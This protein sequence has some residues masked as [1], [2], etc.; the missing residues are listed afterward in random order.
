ML[1]SPPTGTFEVN[2]AAT[3]ILGREPEALLN[4][5]LTDLVHPDDVVDLER[6][7]G[8]VLHGDRET[9]EHRLRAV[10]PGGDTVWLRA[11][12]ALVATGQPSL[13]IQLEDITAF[14]TADAQ[15]AARADR[16]TLTGL[17]TRERFCQLV[18]DALEAT[19]ADHGMLAVVLID[20]D[21]FRD[22][23]DGLGEHAGDLVL[24]E[25]ARRVRA[26]VRRIDA[27]A[28]FGSDEFAVLLPGL[29]AAEDAVAVAAILRS[30]L[31]SPFE[32]GGMQVH[33]SGSVGI[34]VAPGDGGEGRS[35]IQKADVALARA[36]SLRSGWAVYRSQE[37]DFALDRLALAAELRA[38]IEREELDVAYQPIVETRSGRVAELEALA[39][40]RHVDR[41]PIPPDQFIALAEQ[42]DLIAP[43][44]RLILG[45]A[46]AA[47]AGWRRAG[48]D[49]SVAVNLST[50][51][52]GS[53]DFE[54]VVVE[55]LS[56]AG[57]SPEHLTLEITESALAEDVQKLEQALTSLRELGVCL[58]IDDFGTGYSAMSYLKHLPLEV[59]KIDRSFVQAIAA[60]A[61]DVSIVRSLVRLAHS[62]DL[63][64]V[65]EG[66]ESVDAIELL[67]D[68][69][70]D[71]VQGYGIARPMPQDEVPTWLREAAQS[72]RASTGPATA[73]AAAREP[74]DL[75][76]V[77]DSETV[78]RLLAD[79]ARQAGWTVREAASAE[80]ALGEVVAAVPD[81]VVL[82]H[83]LPGMS[84]VQ[85]IPRLRD[86]GLD[87]PILLFTRF[88]TEAMPEIRVP[89][90]VW[91]V[92][93]ANPDGV[94]E[95]LDAYRASATR[96]CI[97][98]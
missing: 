43:L 15:L 41:G 44:T 88:L 89:L 51:V 97:T 22:V 58:V 46:A 91:P 40:W 92:S 83:H 70:C 25:T 55:E 18:G 32:V 79:R 50:Q 54:S 28:R 72:A 64:V 37:D 86:A 9:F 62:L 35:L 93:K 69:E 14:A 38:A 21:G 16:D 77:E 24:Q 34:A 94:L 4:T 47:C 12:A 30:A 42:V 68:I 75:L 84:G 7:I 96:S 20:L 66:V 73:P 95:L 74:R 61:R 56:R 63:R 10:R 85:A 76:I 19:V 17:D 11:R 67:D 71:L 48:H 82:D 29:G 6:L 98:A 65:A 60:D 87:G 3:A 1:W 81:V 23:N 52:L 78:R 13:V 31:E 90:D 5:H 53:A 36:K 33:V 49:V 45:K 8:D 80:E 59:L 2:P 39:R 26:A 57:L 27:V